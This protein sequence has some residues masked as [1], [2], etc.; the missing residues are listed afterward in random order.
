MEGGNGTGGG[1]GTGGAGGKTD[2][3]K[4]GGGTAEAGWAIC[5]PIPAPQFPQKASL[6]SYFIPQF[7]QNPIALSSGVFFR[8]V[9]NH[10]QI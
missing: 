6:T 9:K 10:C 5:S 7:E 2:G 1:G 4:T 3:V 8:L